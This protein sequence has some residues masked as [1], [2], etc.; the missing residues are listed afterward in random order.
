MTNSLSITRVAKTTFASVEARTAADPEM[1]R[2]FKAFLGR[3]QDEDESLKSRDLSMAKTLLGR[4]GG[5]YRQGAAE[6]IRQGDM[7]CY[8]LVNGPMSGLVI[9]ACY[10]QQGIY[11]RLL[12]KTVRQAEVLGRLLPQ[13]TEQLQGR[14]FAIR[15]DVMPVSDAGNS[16]RSFKETL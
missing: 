12:P 9:Q 10:Q 13:L 2:L 16:G 5:V 14:R 15:L 8:R 6:V 1:R 7:L 11:L 3:Q 4:E